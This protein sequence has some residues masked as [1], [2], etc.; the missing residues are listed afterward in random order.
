[1]KTKINTTIAILFILFSI[2]NIAKGQSQLWG[3]T[4]KGGTQFGTI[5][6]I[7]PGANTLTNQ[8]NLPGIAGQ[9]SAYISLNLVKAS[10]GGLYGMT[11]AGG[12]FGF[13]VI[14]QYDPVSDAYTDKINL[15]SITGQDPNGALIQANDN[16]LYGLTNQGGANGV[17]VLFRYDPVNNEYTTMVDLSEAIGSYPN[18]TLLQGNDGMLYGMTSSGGANA[19]GVIFKFDPVN[20]VYTDIYDF[21]ELDGDLPMG[22]LILAS[23]NMLY[24]MT[25]YGGVRNQG[26]LFRYDVASLT[27]SKLYDMDSLTGKWPTGSLF[28]ATDGNLYGM[29]NYG[30]SNSRGYTNGGHGFGVIF[31]FD[32]STDT[33]TDVIDL[34]SLQGCNPYGSFIQGTDGLLYSMT[35]SGGSSNQGTIF[36]YD[37]MN[38]VYSKRVDLNDNT[39]NYPQGSLVQTPDGNIYGMAN[40]PGNVFS[41]VIFQYDP[42]SNT[43]SDKKRISYS[44]GSNPYGSLMQASDGN[45]YG[46]TNN[47]GAY[48]TGVLFQ[49][50]PRTNTYTD[51]IDLNDQTGDLAFGSLVQANDGKL[52]GMTLFGGTNSAGVI[53]QY[54]I[55]TNTYV[56]MVDLSDDLGDYPYGSMV[57]GTDGNLWG[58]NNYGGGNYGGNIFK[59]NP[60][61]NTYS[62]VYDFSDESGDYPNGSLIQASNGK[63]YGMT[64]YGGA[65][66]EGVIF[67]FDPETSAYTDLVDFS[68]ATGS[69]P[70]GSLVQTSNGKMYGFT[71]SGGANGLGVLFEFDPTSNSYSDAID[72]SDDLGSLPNG[73]LMQA[74]NGK[75]YGTTTFGGANNAGTIIEF[76]PTTN[77]YVKKYDFNYLDG[78]NSQFGNL[79]EICTPPDA[80]TLSALI[81]PI[82]SGNATTISIAS[83]NL[84]SAN[85]WQWFTGSCGGTNIGSGS[86]INVHPTASTTYYVRPE[87]QCVSSNTCGSITIGINSNPSLT[88]T[89]AN[90]FCEG[91]SVDIRTNSGY[92]S[93]LWNDNSSDPA[94]TINTSGTYSIVVTDANGC[95]GS[96]E[97]SVSANTLPTATISG[98]TNSC[99]IVNLTASGGETFQWDGGNDPSMATNSFTASGTYSVLVTDNNG[100]SSIASSIVS[101]NPVPAPTI[102]GNSAGCVSVTLSASGGNTYAWSG[103]NNTTASSNTFTSS[104]TYIVSATDIN[105]CVATASKTVTIYSTPTISITS[106][107]NYC[108]NHSAINLNASPTGGTFIGSGVIGS[109]FNPNSAG[110]GNHTI[111]YNYTDGNGCSA[112]ASTTANVIDSPTPIIIAAA[113]S[114]C[115]GSNEILTVTGTFSSYDWSNG[116]HNSMI[117]VI[118]SGDFVVTVTNSAGCTGSASQHIAVIPSPTAFISTSSGNIMCSGITDTLNAGYF[119]QY[120]WSTGSTNQYLNVTASGTYSVTITDVDGCT[121]ST[122][123]TITFNN[124]PTPSITAS[125]PTVFC[126]GGSV[127]LCSNSAY[128]VYNWGTYGA[129]SCVNATTTGTYSLTVT[130]ANGCKG[131][132][133]QSV[134]VNSKPTAAITSTTNVTCAGISN[135]ASTVTA[136][137][138][139]TPYSYSW[140]TNPVSTS[141]TVSNLPAG[142]Y[143]ATVSNATG[144]TASAT[145]VITTISDITKPVIINPLPISVNTDA[146][147]NTATVNLT[148]PTVSD[149]CGVASVS[150]NRTSP[151]FPVGTTI[152][153]WT[154]T[155]NSG[156]SSSASQS[157]VVAD[158]QAPTVAAP[159]TITANPAANSTFATIILAPPTC[160]DNCGIASITN[161]HPSTAFPVGTT[162]VTW[163]ITDVNGNVTTVYQ[164]VVVGDSQAPVAICKNTTIT[165]SGGT[166]TITAAMVDNG[167]YDNIAIASRTVSPSTF[168]CSTLG[169]RTVTLTVYDAAGNSSSCQST[170]NVIG[171]V[172]TRTITVTPSNNT[173]TGGDPS[174]IYIGY[175][176]QTV[177]LSGTCSGGST[178]NH[179]WSGT[180]LSSN[181]CLYPT[182]TPAT[183]C[184]P[185][186]TATVTNEYGCSS[187]SGKNI[188]VKDV[189]DKSH[190]G[191]VLLCHAP[192]GNPSNTQLLSISASAVPAHLQ[193]HPDDHLGVCNT[194]CDDDDSGDDDNERKAQ[195]INVEVNNSNFA[196][197]VYP[198]PTHDKFT[199]SF[200][201][202]ADQN[203]TITIFDMAG[204]PVK[205]EIG[206]AVAGENNH[207]INL[208]GIAQS[209]YQ[210][211]LKIG[212]NDY[213]AKIVIQ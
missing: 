171:A 86:S 72:L 79:I 51:K 8:I 92:D 84:N 40:H 150:K 101:I 88:I 71:S 186:Y 111:S 82:C 138:G 142:N 213:K 210:V 102:S 70:N 121:A 60:S 30:G 180:G 81:N 80:P 77:T 147:T 31:K 39:G 114:I 94:L 183:Y 73:S 78:F 118:D 13:G 53:F 66:G 173:Y 153:V 67:Q 2:G 144:C 196:M 201:A 26:T 90:S 136:S 9:S 6:S 161:N 15:S 33:Y 206:S 212:D 205:S 75:L 167:S 10:D 195:V 165:L 146:N 65:N 12:T 68:D 198:N 191:K 105:G 42:V 93:Y 64:S 152:V 125:G 131:S 49:I 37:F 151:L 57:L 139:S 154:A 204:R 44:D 155:D 124:N 83:G 162:I 1:M 175:G 16:M 103:G 137:G 54:D 32:I 97:I 91:S 58:M 87:G 104:G 182:F 149:N 174:R 157:V 18:G 192:P 7:A 132:A 96:A 115:S 20:D 38:N 62:V 11:P 110:V 160:S 177:T 50:D 76:D 170:V 117:T 159:A 189:R 179:N 45:L 69:Y 128:A 34:N 168:S 133:S 59:Y 74:Q 27:Y 190:A 163:T 35:N 208:S 200:N 187:T 63:F 181:N 127:S 108:S 158:R 95:T 143:I 130:D 3:L 28:Q 29:T 209:V 193:N 55:Q 207:E 56:D 61:T 164:S 211:A 188:C 52:Y 14:F 47:G 141:A 112:N 100:C 23:D 134:T 203:Y 24:G 122:A 99:S 17:G 109:T 126:Q 41:A 4:E 116:I 120:I 113:S 185:S 89:G 106:L 5:F 25:T 172:P 21:T 107:G 199:V 46:L 169:N 202:N 36:S 129:S 194:S 98:N 145:T 19:A 140:N 48:G 43:F 166:A 176:P 85:S 119:D 197:E 22:S 148:A 135:G 178:F 156:N 184:R 123:K